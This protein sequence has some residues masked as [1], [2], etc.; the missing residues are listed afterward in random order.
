MTGLSAGLPTAEVLGYRV[1]RCTRET[2]A[3]WALGAARQTNTPKLLV[4]L[5]PEI[6]VRAEA[7]PQLKAALHGAELTVADG[8]GIIWAARRAGTPLPERVPG[9]ELMTRILEKG[10]PE[11]R[12]Y[13]LGANPGVAQRAAETA[14]ERYG[15]VVAGTQHGYFRRPDEVEEITGTISKSG[16]DVLLAGLG[17]GQEVFL[18]TYRAALKV[19]LLMGVG[20]ALDVLSGEV[21]RT[22]AWTRHMGLEWAYRV[23]FDPKRWHRVPRLV[24]FVK[25]VTAGR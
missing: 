24:Q 10:G 22:P 6:V 15:T 14:R 3:S 18:H 13:F 2:A 21:Q 23:G 8:V 1:A 19:P 5:N 25:M 7:D 11:L 12:V 9:V 17:E 4:T 16:A 20:G